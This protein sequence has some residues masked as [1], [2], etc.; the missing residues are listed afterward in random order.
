MRPHEAH[1]EAMIEVLAG[2]VMIVMAWTMVLIV[3]ALGG[4]R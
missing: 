3:W 2:L 1:Q 4:A